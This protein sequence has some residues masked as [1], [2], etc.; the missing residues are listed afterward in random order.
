G[1]DIRLTIDAGL[2]LAIEQEILAAW[3]ADKAKSVSAIVMHPYTGEILAQASSPSYDANDYAAIAATNPSRF[4]D[5]VISS[6]YEPG[7]VFKM[8]T[9][10]AAMEKHHGTQQTKT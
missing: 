8:L 5:P 9:V 3:A 1:E 10:V 2:Q 4:I 7:S 6:V